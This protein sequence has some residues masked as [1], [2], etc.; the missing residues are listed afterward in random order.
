MSP[1]KLWCTCIYPMEMNVHVVLTV[2]CC[3]SDGPSS[4][5]PSL[6]SPLHLP[7]MGHDPEKW[8][9]FNQQSEGKKS[10]HESLSV[11][12]SLPFEEENSGMFTL[13]RKKKNAEKDGDSPPPLPIPRAAS[14]S[15]DRS[16]V[17]SEHSRVSQISMRTNFL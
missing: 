11:K 14:L 8:P 15:M 9:I 6:P 3:T 10:A 16:S 4:P 12:P 5:L 17:R 1:W 7:Q 2:N 13:K